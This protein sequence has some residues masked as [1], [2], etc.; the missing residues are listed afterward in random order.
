MSMDS[1][2]GVMQGEELDPS[3]LPLQAEKMSIHANAEYGD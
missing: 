1:V 3:L 2:D